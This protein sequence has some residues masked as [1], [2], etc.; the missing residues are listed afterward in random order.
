MVEGLGPRRTLE[1]SDKWSF[2]TT[3]N[4]GL[5]VAPARWKSKAVGPEL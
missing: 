2:L 3:P 5:V 1:D 4:P